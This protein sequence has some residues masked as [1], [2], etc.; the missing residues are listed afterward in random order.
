MKSIMLHP[1]RHHKIREL[2]DE[3]IELYASRDDRLTTFFSESFSGYTVGGSVLV[4][5]RNEWG[6]I[7]LQ[8]FS[9]VP[10]RIRIEMRD[11]AMQDLSENVVVVNAFFNIHLPVPERVLSREV[12]RLV[13]IFRL[14][15]EAWKIVHSGISVPYHL[16]QDGEVYPLNNLQEHNQ[17]LETMVEE[18]T[19][20]LNEREAFYRLLT[21]DT[22]DVLWR[23]DSEFRI[24]YISPSDERLRGYKA[25]EV[26]GRHVFELFNEEGIAIVTE[27]IRKRQ[28]AEREGNPLGF[29]TF[30]AP[31]RC[32][33]GSVIWGEV[34]SK[35]VRD[36]HGKLTGFHGIT[37]EITKRKQMQDQIRQLAF[38][39]PLTQLPNRRL[40]IERLNQALV[41]SKRTGHHG[42]LMFVDLD[43]FKPL[44]DKHGHFVGDLLLIE[45]ANRLKGCVREMDSVSRFGGDEFVVMFGDL[46]AD[47][48][49]SIAHARVVAEKIRV[50]LSDVYKLNATRADET[51]SIIECHCSSSIGVFVFLGHE[52]SAEDILKC[53]DKAMYQAKAAGRNTIR[54]YGAE[55][56]V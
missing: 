29:V 25:E 47:H 46:V 26:V 36:E 38:Y 30:E 21:E 51:E 1:E 27:A 7:I 41:A 55:E 14:E 35:A 17:V 49:K 16:V 6:K 54:F 53:A 39:D 11:I 48:T 15:D 45:A 4:T 20:T 40:L 33:D 43:N 8:D 56:Q 28:Q 44:N 19:R 52:D 50:R 32:K 31:H 10:G 23:A 18:R 9:E 3:Y 2:F 5:D 24:T 22:M 34:F 42:A 12:A 13:L 37:R